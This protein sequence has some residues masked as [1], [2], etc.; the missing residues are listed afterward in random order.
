MRAQG[1]IVEWVNLEEAPHS[2]QQLAW[3]PR[4][5]QEIEPAAAAIPIPGGRDKLMELLDQIVVAK[6]GSKFGRLFTECGGVGGLLRLS[7][8]KK[9]HR[10]LM[11]LA[12]SSPS[13]LVDQLR[14]RVVAVEGGALGRG[15]GATCV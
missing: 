5:V 9:Q 14:R 2:Y 10:A 12:C 6:T 3:R 11:G 4:D 1:D 13:E 8:A 7:H 15:P